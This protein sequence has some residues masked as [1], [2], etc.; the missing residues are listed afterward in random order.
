MVR[1]CEGKSSRI[2]FVAVGTHRST[3]SLDSVTESDSI[4]SR[5]GVGPSGRDSMSRLLF[6]RNDLLIALMRISR[7]GCGV[8]LLLA[9]SFAV[10]A[11]AQERT[12][13]VSSELDAALQE[14]ESEDDGEV[15]EEPDRF[16]RTA[17]K[18]RDDDDDAHRSRS[19][20]T[21]TQTQ[22]SDDGAGVIGQAGHLAFKTFGRTQSITPIEAMPYILTDE[23][24]I[25]SDLRGFVS[26]SAL[27]GGNV[28][29]GYR[30][31]REDLN[32]WFGGSVWYDADGTTGRTYQQI[33]LSFEGLVD[34]WEFRS[35]V[36]LP[37]SSAQ[38]YANTLGNERIVGHQLLYSRFI[39][40]GKAL[41]GVD[42]EAG[43]NLPIKETNRLR[44]FVGYYH[45]DGGPTGGINGFKTRLEGVINNAV[46]AQVMYTNDKLYGS[47]V[48]VGCQIQFPWGASHPTSKWN[49]N[50]PSPFRFVERNYNVIVD[51]NQTRD[52]NLV[53]INPL[54]H[55]AYKVEQVSSAAG[56]GGDGTTTNPYQTIAAAQA[57]GGDLILV[58][59][60]SVITSAV[61][62]TS[63]QH[64]IGDGSH[65][66]IALNGGGTI[67]MPTQIAGGATPMFSG[68][69]GNA[70][71]MASGS[72]VTGFKFSNINGGGIVG[73]NV[74]GATLRDLTFQ[75]ITGDAVKFTNSS[76]KFT[77]DNI[78]VNTASASGIS[79]VGGTPDLT[80][81]ANI[82]GTGTDGILLSGL[83]GGSV[84]IFGTS[85]TSTGGAGLRL[86]NVS[87]DVTVDSLK[88]SQT[89]GSAVMLSGGTADD[90]YHFTNTTTIN[91]PNGIGFNV[92][93]ATAAV[94]VD[95]LVVNSTAGSPAVSLTNSTGTITLGNVKATTTNAVGLY[96][97]GLTKLVVNNGSLTT[98]N[99]GAIDVQN[100]TIKMNLAQVSVDSG[101]FGIQLVNNVGT[102]N[103]L[104]GA[105]NG[106]GGT[107]KNTTTGLILNSTG[108]TSIA[109]LDLTNNG[110]GILSTSNTQ[111][112]LNGL[113]ITGSSNYALDSLDD[114]M[115]ILKNSI[116]TG[117]GAIGGGTI[118]AQVD[119]VAS[120][121][122]L[123]D[124]NT[125]IDHNGT[126][127]LMKTLAAGNG[128]S[129]GT[130]ISNNTITADRAGAAGIDVEWVGP[131]S[132]SVAS[133]TINIGAANMTGIIVRDTS[134]TDSVVARINNNL[135]KFDSSSSNGTG[136][137]ASAAAGSTFQVDTNGID[138]K[139]VNGTGLRFNLGGV[140]SS[141]IY[142]NVIADEA[143]GATGMLFD[144]VAASSRLQI[145]A[146]QISLLAGDLTIHRGIV[147]TTV[148]P[149]I[150][151]S[152]N[153]NNVITN[154]STVFSIPVNSSTGHIIINGSQ[155]P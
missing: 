119:K 56:A 72:E 100:S 17:A 55:T 45:F 130:T 131:L 153:Y 105:T 136:I 60:N 50:T 89:S 155:A 53:A 77:L 148:S 133:N 81:S 140:S 63:G 38:T 29:L 26:N 46:T 1:H 95:N 125:I 33:G 18:R 65:A 71:T 104:G 66:A 92:N 126:A 48:M 151:F 4:A 7:L 79:F 91:Q 123:I 139:A 143:G 90:T 16:R 27:F 152:G 150:Q 80:L 28:G 58:Q 70:V 82:N 94:V 25:F 3:H 93:N 68:I 121:Q 138:F 31:L 40:Q 34:R 137:V 76:G 6:A 115:L 141:W 86:N 99:A 78:A 13:N 61:T 54:T 111:L 23:H 49:Q 106:S 73:T 118:R 41:Q 97:R 84:N 103:I 36:Y 124:S 109:A 8:A 113:R 44:G 32:A 98:V 87:T 52:D 19:S 59:G 15:S 10:P 132:A 142:S 43:Y 12:R 35:N 2:L 146:N 129:L 122:W 108:T 107:I 110:T 9:V 24:F 147:F 74:N 102:F 69:T 30:H 85:I 134:G 114:S 88:T 37:F 67:Y 117:N 149:T 42:I 5:N 21:Y 62:L 128:A 144:T 101:P 120:F 14:E 127:I 112:T 75:N 39:D 145:E 135:L 51:R 64:L 83:T 47:N 57:A 11:A 96:G 22:K 116:L 154:A 20:R